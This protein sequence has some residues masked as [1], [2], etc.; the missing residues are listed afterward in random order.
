MPLLQNL[1]KRLAD[2]DEL[3]FLAWVFVCGSCLFVYPGDV[4]WPPW[5]FSTVVSLIIMSLCV[6]VFL[7][8]APGINFLY[9]SIQPLVIG[10]WTP[11]AHNLTLAQAQALRHMTL[12]SILSLV[13]LTFV[14]V[15]LDGKAVRNA[16]A[17]LFALVLVSFLLFRFSGFG[18]ESL[19]GSKTMGATFLVLTFPFLP[20]RLAILLA[21]PLAVLLFFEN[22]A[23]A[24]VAYA[25]VMSV[26]SVGWLPRGAK[27]YLWVLPVLAVLSV[28]L[29][30]PSTFIHKDRY[31]VW[32]MEIS[33]WWA[34]H[35]HI[36]GYG[37][38]AYKLWGPYYQA[39][40]GGVD[41]R[42]LWIW[43]HN[44]WL[45]CLLE[46]GL[47]GIALSIWL[48]VD[49]FLIFV[50]SRDF[51]HLAVLSALGWVLLVN[52]TANIAIFAVLGFY[53]VVQAY[54]AGEVK[55]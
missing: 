26:L 22:S 43:P 10:S 24:W 42:H 28:P 8:L 14:L 3:S 32:A 9:W 52:Y 6:V 21:L 41:P 54:H 15:V 44:D 4:W 50:R 29:V 30:A 17:F 19:L 49:C 35:S 16:F 37:K 34:H 12:E 5:F 47:V 27:R 53:L 31:D 46:G 20:R 11:L 55:Q 18:F 33:G 25:I 40:V 36:F 23:T 7:D 2:T 1:Q 13:C 38:G 45:Q 51:H 48:Y 39:T